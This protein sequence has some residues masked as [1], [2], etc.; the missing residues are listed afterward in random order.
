MGKAGRLLVLLVAL[1][2]LGCASDGIQLTPS[3]IN[4]SQELAQAPL[5]CLVAEMDNL[6]DTLQREPTME[7]LAEV[8]YSYTPRCM[9]HFKPVREYLK[10][11]NASS[12]FIRNY[13]RVTEESLTPK[14]L[15]IILNRKQSNEQ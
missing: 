5:M 9:R 4:R 1:V 6:A 10:S 8:G 3:Q 2:L 12:T 11:C 14:A 13:E 15:K 7:E